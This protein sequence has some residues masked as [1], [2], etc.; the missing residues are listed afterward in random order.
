MQKILSKRILRDLKENFMRYLALSALIILSMYV[1]I[2][3]IGTAD[4]IILGTEK[5]T[6]SNRLEDGEFSLFIPLS[7]EEKEELMNQGITLEEQFYL[8]YAVEDGST[9]RI[10]KNRENINLLE[11]VE[12]KEA[13]TASELVI[14]RRYADEHDIEI[15]DSFEIGNAIF[16]VVGI[17]CSPDYDAPLKN[18]TDGSVDSFQFGTVF[19]TAEAYEQLLEGGGSLRAEE[20]VYAYLLN[21]KMTDEELREIIEELKVDADTIPDEFFREYW[22]EMTADKTELEDGIASLVD[23]SGELADG[24]SE[25]A[26]G[27]GEIALRDGTAQLRDGAEELHDGLTELQDETDR[28]LEEYFNFELSNMRSFLKAG[29]N[30]RI[31]AAAN[32]Q[33]LNKYG[34]LIAGGIVLVLFAYVISVFVVYG[35]EKENTTI[36]AL[37]ALGVKRNELIL[38][39]LC[40]PVIISFLAGAIGCMIGFAS[41]GG[42][43]I[44]GSCYSYFSIPN[45]ESVY[46]PYL[47]VYGLVLPP[48][49]SALVNWFVIR[50]KLNRPALQMLKNEQKSRHMK[51]VRLGKM[52]FVRAFRIRQIIREARTS[53]TVIGGMFISLLILMLGLDCYVMCRHISEDN[54]TDTKFEYL[55]TYKYP[56]EMVPDGGYEAFTRTVKKETMGYNLEIAILGITQENPFFEVSLTD[57]KSEVV[58]SSALAEKYGLKKG[59]VFVVED[60][61][62]KMH[63]AFTVHDITQYATSF[64]IFMDIA[65]M[66]EMFGMD[67]NY[68]NQVFSDRELDIETGRLYGVTTKK[69]IEKA[70]DVFIQQM[71]SMVVMMTVVSSLIFAVVMYLMIKVMIDRCAFHISMVKVFGY[72]TKEIKKLYLDGNFYVIAVGAAICIPLAKKCMDLMYPFM[73]SNI[74]CGMNLHFPWQIYA[75]V[76]VAVLVLYFVINGLLTSK[77]KKVNLAEVLKNR[78]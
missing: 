58:I 17:G 53:F 57:S 69:D 28:L 40:L 31:L 18:F 24:L 46:P 50:G 23:G 12:G 4:T 21:G 60:E 32:D 48:V 16:T 72:R 63:Y 15:G 41:I 61:E 37:Y 3:L 20:Y 71:G 54:K 64:Y 7:D 11:I 75:I 47:I 6:E 55:Y 29:D 49:I 26:E 35:I 8:D 68:Y 34:G 13:K 44:M 38:H 14:E 22:N 67:E 51:Q 42:S 10:L 2:S 19:V 56:E 52:N 5:L 33:V 25:L 45:M 43:T 73:V 30:P 74:S 66:R 9:V 76:Y 78:E 39:Y 1:I 59:D 27:A 65:C 70:A 77:L 36:G 62:A